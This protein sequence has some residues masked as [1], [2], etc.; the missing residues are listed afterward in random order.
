MRVAVL[1]AGGPAGHNVSHSLMQAGH[2]VVAIE[3]NAL[4]LPLA[5]GDTEPL[6]PDMEVIQHPP[7]DFNFINWL[8]KVCR[9]H[10]IDYIHP[11]PDSLV[12]HVARYGNGLEAATLLPSVGTVQLCQDKFDCGI[13]WR[14][15]GLRGTRILPIEAP[16]DIAAAGRELGYPFWLRAR[17]GAG[18]RG[19]T[20]VH[21]Q[22]MGE[23]WLGYW[24]S[25][26]SDWDFV[27]EEFLPGRDYA[28]TSLWFRGS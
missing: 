2:E 16:Y 19:A 1:G 9:K 3:G 24:F 6:H 18:A 21:S 12:E 13:A 5:R 27:A 23:H 17:R 15:A 10:E 11:Q 20:E 28:W 25:R 7:L 4:H 8:N 26:G 22:V 14:R